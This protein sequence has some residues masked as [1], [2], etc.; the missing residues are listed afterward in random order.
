[1]KIADPERRSVEFVSNGLA[2]CHMEELLEENVKDFTIPKKQVII[3]TAAGKPVY[4]YGRD[5]SDISGMCCC[6]VQHQV[7]L[8]LFRHLTRISLPRTRI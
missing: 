4:S 6:L 5:E 3:L 2:G 1:M 8:L 7:S